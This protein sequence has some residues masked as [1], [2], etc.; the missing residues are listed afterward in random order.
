MSRF[1]LDLSNLLRHA[2]ISGFEAK[3][4]TV[5]EA[6]GHWP[7]YDPEDCSAYVRV[8]SAVRDQRATSLEEAAI[9]TECHFDDRGN[10]R[11]GHHSEMDWTD[12][13]RDATRGAAAAIRTALSRP[14]GKEMV[15]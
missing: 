11:S 4:G 12:G 14:A 8:C 7:E 3:G 1:E 6:I 15:R 13:Y 10:G 9:I 2:F 5:T